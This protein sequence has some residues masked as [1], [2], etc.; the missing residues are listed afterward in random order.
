MDLD[1]DDTYLYGGSFTISWRN[2]I[3]ASALETDA[4]QIRIFF[5]WN[6]Q[7]KEAGFETEKTYITEGWIGHAATSGSFDFDGTQVP[8]T[9]SG[10][11]S[12]VITSAGGGIWSD[13]I[14]IDIDQ[15]RDFIWSYYWNPALGG[16]DRNG[17]QWIAAPRTGTFPNYIN[18]QL[19][20]TRHGVKT[21]SNEASA[22]VWVGSISTNQFVH[23]I[24]YICKVS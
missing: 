19:E 12:F 20:G 14:N 1:I 24:Q 9:V 7:A 22:S 17:S 16:G 3:P 21:K 10:S 13:P 18:E 11:T 8:V 23:G 5:A 2:L 6:Q 15:S 4:N